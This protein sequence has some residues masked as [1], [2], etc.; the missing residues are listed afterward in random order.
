MLTNSQLL[1]III[2]LAGLFTAFVGTM[3]IVM[4]WWFESTR[5]TGYA[6]TVV[7]VLMWLQA[8]PVLKASDRAEMKQKFL[9]ELNRR[10]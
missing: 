8:I 9:E 10:K 5:T 3:Y 6:I 4:P 1:R 2:G 7:G